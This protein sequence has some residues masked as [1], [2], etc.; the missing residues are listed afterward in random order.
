M[1]R[2]IGHMND[3]VVRNYW[4][5]KNEE[6]AQ[7]NQALAEFQ[8]KERARGWLG[9]IFPGTPPQAPAEPPTYMLSRGREL[10]LL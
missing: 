8:K 5:S 2:L 7:Y 4:K 6:Y 10:N 9:R 1:N 3:T